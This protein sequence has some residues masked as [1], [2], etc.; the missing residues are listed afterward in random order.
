M[1]RGGAG[2]LGGLANGSRSS[3]WAMV[4]LLPKHSAYWQDG[5]YHWVEQLQCELVALL[6][7]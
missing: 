4:R 1:A 6:I 3:E 5:H 7:R 2:A